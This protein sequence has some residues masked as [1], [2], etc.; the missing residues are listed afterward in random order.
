[1]INNDR[2]PRLFICHSAQDYDFAGWLADSLRQ[3]GHNVWLATKNTLGGGSTIETI[4]QALDESDVMLLVV[5]PNALKSALITREWTYF[6]CDCE[7]KLIPIL[8]EPPDRINFMLASLQYMDFYKQD[9][10]TA[11]SS[12]HLTLH[13][14]YTHVDKYTQPAKDIVSPNF[15]F[16][17]RGYDETGERLQASQVGLIQV[18]PNFPV[19]VYLSWMRA[20]NS[21]IWLLNTWT[22]IIDY[23][24]LFIEAIDRGVNVMLLL[25]DPSSPFARQR[26]L[27][28]QLGSNNG[29]P[30]ENQV[31]NNI[32]ASIRRMANA[33]L[34]VANLRERLE[35]RLYNLLPSFSICGCDDKAFV[36]FFPHS[37]KTSDFAVLEIRMDTLFGDQ[38]AAEFERIWQHATP[39]DLS[40]HTP[41]HLTTTDQVLTEP[42]SERELEILRLISDGLSN[43]EIANRLIV[44]VATVKKHINNLYGKLGVSSRTLAMLRARELN[45]I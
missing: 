30:D 26:S 42:L 14:V 5:T 34:T 18:H 25:L 35:L 45:L 2:V 12:L 4:H 22:G 38:V 40:P 44:T 17:A 9:R 15:S 29:P 20:A 24:Q 8:L 6:Y 28:L 3:L 10:E 43:Q 11:L 1:M 27:D 36:G 31:P 21:R 23:D 19:D 39:V 32:R 41:T 7:K 37:A 33:Y 13:E 16:R